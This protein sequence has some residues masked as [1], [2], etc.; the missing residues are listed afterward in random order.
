VAETAAVAS[1]ATIKDATEVVLNDGPVEVRLPI[2]KPKN[3]CNV[4]K[5]IQKEWDREVTRLNT[6]L[7]QKIPGLG[8]K[9]LV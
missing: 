5:I 7:N 3:E 8:E 4:I 9:S 2:F 6:R 1:S